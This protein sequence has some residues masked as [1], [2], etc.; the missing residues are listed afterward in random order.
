[1]NYSHRKNQNYTHNSTVSHLRSWLFLILASVF[2][3]MSLNACT[4]SRPSPQASLLNALTER[5][6]LSDQAKTY[7]LS[8]KLYSRLRNLDPSNISYHVGYVRALRHTKDLTTF[9]KYQE[10]LDNSQ[11]NGQVNL[12]TEHVF[13]MLSFDLNTAAIQLLDDQKEY[14]KPKAS[15]HWLRGAIFLNEGKNELAEDQYK[16]CLSQAPKDEGCLYDYVLLLQKTTQNAKA[17]SL[18]RK[19][20]RLDLMEILDDEN[21][22]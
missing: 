4:S 7:H 15:Y 5:A 14:I 16:L 1:M 3:I 8:A 12:L 18:L 11:F 19:M 6:Q 20:N 21:R 22:S 2:F 9:L 13:T 17:Q 10:T